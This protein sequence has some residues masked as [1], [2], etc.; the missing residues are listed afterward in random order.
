MK[1]YNGVVTIAVDSDGVPL[2]KFWRNRLKDSEI[3]NC[4]EVIKPSQT[5]KDK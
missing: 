1:G 2:S 3:D 4:V 5:K